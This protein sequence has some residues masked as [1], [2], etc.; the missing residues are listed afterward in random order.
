MKR[1]RKPR[2]WWQTDLYRQRSINGGATLINV[3]KE[4]EISGQ[5]KNFIR[6]SSTDFEYLLNLV[7]PRIVKQDTAFRKAISVTERLAVTLRFYA[8]GD[9]Y[10]SLQFLFKISRQR[11]GFI[12]KEVSEAIVAELIQNIQVTTYITFRKHVVLKLIYTKS[13]KSAKLSWELSSE[14]GNKSVFRERGLKAVTSWLS[15]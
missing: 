8:S 10:T 7:A 3:L 12:V 2:R 14:C 1:K 4:Q 11:I 15:S 13:E 5:Y 6:M 9:S